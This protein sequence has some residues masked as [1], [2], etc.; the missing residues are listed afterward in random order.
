MNMARDSLENLNFRW[1]HQ[2]I[3]SISTTQKPTCAH[4]TS[5]VPK[6]RKC[7]WMSR[8]SHANSYFNQCSGGL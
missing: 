1:L 8:I 5:A 2:I 7:S 6:Q 3:Y 4:S